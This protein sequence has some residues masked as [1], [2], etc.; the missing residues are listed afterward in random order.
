MSGGPRLTGQTVVVIG[1]SSGIGLETARRA[2]E[3]GAEVILTARDPDRLHRVGLELGAATA[4]FDVNDGDGLMRFFTDLPGPVDHLLV[5]GSGPHYVPFS[6]L[7]TFAIRQ[8]VERIVLSVEI[9]RLAR[10]AL[11][12]PG[13]LLFIGGTNGRRASAGPLICAVTAA[14]PALVRSLAFELAPVRVNLL[15]PG[16]VD[17]PLSAA[18]L[19][20]ELD[21]RREQ[22][23]GTL[24]IRR[25]VQPEDV[26]AL[27]I[28]LMVNTAVTG[29]TFDIDG[30]QQLVE[31]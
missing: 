31:A 4:A 29:A 18:I 25:V 7:D 26:A 23:R 6:E 17:T 13:S 22:L 14:M 12:P 27:A 1:G 30:G 16:F 19:G 28:D 8:G 10:D 24:P 3:E 21:A 20:K 15:A 11:R 9:A 5:S 2:R